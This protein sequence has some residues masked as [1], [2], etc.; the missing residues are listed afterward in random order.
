MAADLFAR[1]TSDEKLEFLRLVNPE[2]L[3]SWLATLELTDDPEAC[4]AF[5]RGQA[6]LAAGRE[7][8]IPL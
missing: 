5:E 3:E 2:E 6:D 4:K 1:M 7:R 8:E